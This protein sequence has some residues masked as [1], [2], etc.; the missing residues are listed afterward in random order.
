MM[1]ATINLGGKEVVL[2]LAH[3][4]TPRHA[5]SSADISWI[6]L[7]LQ[8]EVHTGLPII[9]ASG[10]KGTFREVAEKDWGKERTDGIF[11]PDTEESSEYSS[12]IAFTDLRLLLFP[13]RSWKGIFVWASCPLVLERLR[14]D[15]QVLGLGSYLSVP[16]EI[17][18]K[19]NNALVAD[20]A[21]LVGEN[22]LILE[23]F[24]FEAREDHGLK[25]FAQDLQKS[26]FPGDKDFWGQKLETSL[27]ILSNESFLSFA[28]FSTE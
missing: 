24:V 23:D 28:R 16:T 21:V 4:V 15:L 20:K 6:D 13:V 26:L 7:P 3:A 12:A 27:V 17:N 14:R 8:R 25:G 19:N 22:R 5:G 1:T 18:I 2:F 11:G 9:Q 10:V